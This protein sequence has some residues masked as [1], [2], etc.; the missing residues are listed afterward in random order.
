MLTDAKVVVCSRGHHDSQPMPLLRHG[1][2]ALPQRRQPRVELRARRWHR[3][4]YCGEALRTLPSAVTLTCSL[5]KS[6]VH[7]FGIQAP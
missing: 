5:T 3:H 4:S 6:Q 7:C 2:T 1:S